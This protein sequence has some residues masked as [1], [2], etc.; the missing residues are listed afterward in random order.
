MTLLAWRYSADRLIGNLTRMLGKHRSF[1]V[2]KYVWTF[3][4]PTMLAFAIVF[5]LVKFE[6]I[7][8]G[9]YVFPEWT[10][11]IGWCLTAITLSPVP[12]YAVYK[13]VTFKRYEGQQMSWLKVLDH[14]TLPSDKWGP[15]LPQY[16]F[17]GVDMGEDEEK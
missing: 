8:Y 13:L 17:M 10:S 2:W 11:S 14:L 16:R 3:I 15:V 9:D 5:T 1:I 4:S 12:I 7:K 6:P